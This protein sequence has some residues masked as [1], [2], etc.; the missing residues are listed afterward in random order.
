MS[1]QQFFLILRSRYKL[2]LTV[3]L[4]TMTLTLLVSLLLP[5]RYTSTTS[6]V[7]D[8]RTPDPIG[9]LVL[10]ATMM[11]S[12]M[13]TQ[14]DIV[15]S[16]RVARKVVSLLKLDQSPAIK[17]Q[18]LEATDGRGRLDVWL[19]ELLQKKLTVKPSRES[20]V[21]NISFVSADPAFSAAVANAF[22]Q[23]YI[24]TNVE[25]KVEPARQYSKWFQVQTG[26]LRENL[27]R[28]QARLSDYQ[29]KEGIVV[30]DE[31][32]DSENAKLN[33]LSTQLTIVQGQTTDT[34]SKQR[35]GGGAANLPEFMQN[36]VIQNLR[37]DIARLEAKLK[38]ASGNFGVNHP[39]YQRMHA[40]LEV[41][42]QK[43]DAE[44]RHV[45][46]GFASASNVGREKEAALKRMI[47]E[48][49]DKL[50]ELK[51]QRDQAAVLLGDV[52]AAQ[53]S[54]DAVAQ[55]FTQTSLESQTT[56]TN[57]SVL[58]P[59]VVPIAPS[60]PLPLLYTL[61]AGL[62]GLVLGVAAAFGM[63]M[64]DRRVRTADD[65]EYGLGFALP[66]L[67]ELDRQGG[68]ASRSWLR[69]GRLAPPR[70]PEFVS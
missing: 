29:Q 25:L 27:E 30:T 63:E 54:F 55:R 65:L 57:I 42:R 58:T 22:A 62:V 47:A 13:P 60:S 5:N 10:P 39:Q 52:A 26:S 53:K 18:W 8:V 34:L 45:A 67:V 69:I 3:L 33:E 4:A 23:A 14:I 24:E 31:R 41:L 37:I 19:G 7:V 36:P 50:L 6:V 66:V 28:A 11:A 2:A 51:H 21:I 44:G 20:D 12:Y 48:Q 70:L 15:N 16:E 40:E 59:A 64:S 32:L 43:L 17:E 49:K 9:G 56:Q 35:S 46:G 38:E 61:I 68:L 1:L